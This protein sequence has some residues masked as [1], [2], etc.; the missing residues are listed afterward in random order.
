[1]S[2][3]CCRNVVRVAGVMGGCVLSLSAA[4]CM[5]PQMDEPVARVVPHSSKVYGPARVDDYFWLRER[6][7]PDVITY[8]QLENAYTKGMTKHTVR[9]QDRLYKEMKGR[10]KETDEGVPIPDGD[11]VYYSR[12]FEGKQYSVQCRKRKGDDA[13]EQVILDQ[14]ELAEGHKYFRLANMRVS[15]DHNLLAFATDTN[16]SETYTLHVKDLRTG[17]MLSDRVDNTYYGLEWG[18]DNKTLFY[19][20]LDDAKRPYKCFRHTLGGRDD[21]LVY[22]EADEKFHLSIAKSQS[23]KFVFVQLA[24]QVTAEIR[25]LDAD[26][27]AGAFRVVSPRVQGVEYSVAHH[28]SSFY[29]TTND[30]ATNFKVVRAPV[31]NPDRANWSEFIRHDPRVKIEGVTPFANHLVISERSDGLRRIRVRDLRN[32]SEH[33]LAFDEPVYVAYVGSNREFNTATLRVRYTSMVTPSSEYDYQMDTK[34]RELMKRD[35]VL[36]GY[37]PSNYESK[38][39]F[40]TAPDGTQVPIS[41]VHRRGIALDGTNPT[42]LYGYG[43][44]GASMEPWFRSSLIS[45]LDRGFVFAIGH[46]R[47]GGEM[48]RAWYEDGKLLK[49]KNTFTDFIACAEHLIAKGYTSPEKLAIQGGSAGGLLMGAVTNMRPDLFHVVVAQ[50]PFVDVVN[51]MLDETIPLT[52]IEFE[53]W[54]NPKERAFYDYMLSYSPYDNVSAKGYPNMLVTA[55]LNDP[56]VQYWEPAKWVAKLRSTRTDDNVL[57]LKTNMGAGHG[58]ASGR[59][60]RLKDTAFVYAFILDMLGID[61]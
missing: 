33:Y 16:G 12:T 5:R 3:I 53:E 42:L 48:G 26:H 31:S 14:N 23:E 54:G 9:L 20:V 41:L 15:P 34:T 60:G 27:P 13:S 4:S 45:L 43:S 40:A 19:T 29:I 30:N 32:A 7:S 44:Y 36:G 21:E 52:V 39:V 11:Y 37:D 56:R 61:S 55:G 1:M 8:L 50:V 59:Y 49:K 38:R 46:I 2:L 35:E 57:L 22:H 58:G 10:I 51:T 28:G 47:G 25:F 17:E 6:T 24:S 18:N